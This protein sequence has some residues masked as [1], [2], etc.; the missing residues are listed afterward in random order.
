MLSVLAAGWILLAGAASPVAP[1]G[2]I[3]PVDGIVAKEFKETIRKRGS[4]G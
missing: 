3:L 4:R 2:V 1:G